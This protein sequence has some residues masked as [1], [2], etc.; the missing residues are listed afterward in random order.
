VFRPWLF[1]LQR[2]Q[3][4]LV[5]TAPLRK[6]VHTKMGQRSVQRKVTIGMTSLS[7]GISTL[8]SEE[9]LR[10]NLTTLT[11][12]SSAIP[13]VF[14]PIEYNGTRF[15]D[16]GLTSNILT[17]RGIDRC[18]AEGKTEIVLT[19]ILCRPPIPTVSAA[20]VS[21]WGFLE[22]AAREAAVASNVLFDHALRYKCRP[23]EHSSI[24]ARVYYPAPGALGHDPLAAINFDHG[25]RY[26]QAGNTTGPPDEWDYCL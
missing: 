19:I 26:F 2:Q 5:D 14:P 8:V 25:E 23:G 11:L 13:V 10:N 24:K 7:T 12:A 18:R 1:P 15:V 9:E 3:P 22:I 20:E 17:L 21:S 6:T 16:G 4:G